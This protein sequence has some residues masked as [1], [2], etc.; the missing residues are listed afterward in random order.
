MLRGKSDSEWTKHWVVLA[1]LSLKLYRDVWAE[2]STEPLISIDLADCENVYPSASARN[3]GIE[4]RCRKQRFVLSAMTPGIRDSWINALQQNRH[5]PSPTYTEPNSADALSL[6]DSSDILGSTAIR[7][8]HIA[9][10][11]P[12]SHHS[13]SMMDEES[14]TEDEQSSNRGTGN[15]SGRNERNKPRHIRNGNATGQQ[16]PLTFATN[17]LEIVGSRTRKSRGRRSQNRSHSASS[18]DAADGNGREKRE[19]LSPSFRR[20]PVARI[21]ERSQDSRQRHPSNSSNA[22]STIRSNSNKKTATLRSLPRN[23]A[24]SQNQPIST[25]S[26]TLANPTSFAQPSSHSQEARLISLEEQVRSLRDQLE[27]TSS[28]LGTTQ[29]EN[30][31]LKYLFNN[32][33]ATSLSGLRQSLS[34][35]EEEV[36]KRQTEMESLRRQLATPHPSE[37]LLT[38]LQ[39]R[40]LSMARV[41][42]QALTVIARNRLVTQPEQMLDNVQDIEKRLNEANA[43]DFDCVSHIIQDI[44]VLFDEM[45][46]SLKAPNV[47]DSWTITDL[48][49]SSEDVDVKQD[50]EWEAEMTAI[51]NSHYSEI[52]SLKHHYE[53][54]L[55]GLKEKVETEESKRRKAQDELAMNTSRN[56]QSLST[57]KNSFNELIEEQKRGYE[58]EIDILKTEHIKELEEEKNATRVALEV[59]RRAHEEELRQLAERNRSGSERDAG[60]QNRVIE[61]M[62]EELTNLSALY[63]AKCV[64]NSMLDE[65]IAALLEN[66]NCDEVLRAELRSKEAELQELRKRI[67]LLEDKIVR[68]TIEDSDRD[69][70]DE[71]HPAGAA[72]EE[73][74]NGSG[75]GQVHQAQA[76]R[77][78]RQTNGTNASVRFRRAQAHKNRRTD[79]RFHSNPVIPMVDGVP[80]YM[81]DEVRRSLAVPVAERRKFFETIAEYSTPF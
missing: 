79:I 41:Q 13:N 18:N 5:N 40:L 7:K 12:E 43:T 81:L 50:S 51:K 60:R 45:A 62:R 17:Y 42:L 64:E 19:S 8:K 76:G 23:A 35:A 47:S 52:E 71:A 2:D 73:K 30:E 25:P 21:K 1:G 49:G 9:Y 36:R 78:E 59:V 4:I 20:S 46:H 27:E 34:H 24:S 10:V 33:E 14:S 6:A 48:S 39:D 11:A 31:R 70:S 16:Q 67:A 56:G 32:N 68:D 38:N 22:S 80:E 65:K 74:M 26:T 72:G 54:Q 28:R 53:H 3:Y 69:E 55:K 58:S 57:V 77:A 75:L 37:Q 66:N 63:S 15:S 29:H 44:T 61:Q